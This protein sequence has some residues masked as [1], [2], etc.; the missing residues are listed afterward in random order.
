MQEINFDAVDD[1]EISSVAVNK[2][3]RRLSTVNETGSSASS[4]VVAAASVESV[5]TGNSVQLVAATVLQ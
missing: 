3:S 1:D 5:V 4:I 2:K